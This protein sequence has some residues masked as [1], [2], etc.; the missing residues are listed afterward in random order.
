MISRCSIEA[1]TDLEAKLEDDGAK[2]EKKRLEVGVVSLITA[3]RIQPAEAWTTR[4]RRR[5]RLEPRRAGDHGSR[6][7]SER[8]F[9]RL[10]ASETVKT[11]PAKSPADTEE[12]GALVALTAEDLHYAKVLK[13]D[14]KKVAAQKAE[15]Q[16]R[17]RA[18]IGGA[19]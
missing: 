11:P 6:R 8:C 9:D 4:R 16:S 7:S 15:E 19:A 3:G 14:P 5:A 10:T 17:R 13:L 2:K 12:G 18:E 1:G